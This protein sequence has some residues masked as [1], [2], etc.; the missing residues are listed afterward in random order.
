M[1]HPLLSPQ[2]AFPAASLG[3]RLAAMLYDALLCTALLIV[4]AFTYKL[5]WIAFVGEAHM[6]TLTESG[7]LD[8]D[9]ILSTLLLFVLFGFF[10]TFWTHS[11][12]TLG[13]QV[14]GVRV[15]NAD[16]SRISLWQ[17]LLRFMVS[18]ASWLCVGLGFVWSLFDKHKRC[19]HDI[20]SDTQLV[21]IA[22]Q[23]K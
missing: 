19:W 10:A 7:T 8:G 21:R 18:I 9:P 12:Q 13:M 3:R 20:Y 23:K 4:T 17:A 6:R 16:G 2:G 14:W 22:Q 5:V 1:A 15:Q 11:G